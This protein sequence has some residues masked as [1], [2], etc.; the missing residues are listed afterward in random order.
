MCVKIVNNS[1]EVPYDCSRPLEDQLNG[2]E[3]IVVNYEPFDKSVDAL[4]AE[5]ERIARTGVDA[6]LRIK[7]IHNDHIF[8]FNVKQKLK[9]ATNNITLNEI[10]KLMVLTH[11][12]IDRKLEDLAN[13]FNGKINER[14]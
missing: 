12:S 6:R 9:R 1:E 4:L 13:T 8:G 14:A 2:A 11:R 5:V 10:I 3:Q 7:V